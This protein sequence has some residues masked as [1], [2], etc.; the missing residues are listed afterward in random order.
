MEI[1]ETEQLK[2][3]IPANPDINIP[4]STVSSCTNEGGCD[5]DFCVPGIV[6][7]GFLGSIWTWIIIIITGVVIWMS[8]VLL[9]TNSEWYKSL[10]KPTALISDWGFVVI[11]T[12]LYIGL[13]ITI[14][15]AGWKETNP[16]SGCMVLLYV[17]IIL[18]TLCWIIAFMQFHMMGLG[19]TIL[20]LILVL[21]LWLMWLVTPPRNSSG[22]WFP[23][24]FLWIFFFWIVIALYYNIAFLVLNPDA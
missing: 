15:M 19:I 4:E 22:G 3:I 18:L 23:H 20:I 14:I 13:I 9:D 7:N 1:V 16:R 2:I 6:K 24:I 10:V 8:I 5:T 17:L 12:I 21:I 11:W